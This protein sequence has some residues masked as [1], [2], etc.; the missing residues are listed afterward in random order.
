MNT[1]AHFIYIKPTDE[2]LG[3][4]DYSEN[5]KNKRSPTKTSSAV[6]SVHI[7]CFP[8]NR[9]KK[10]LVSNEPFCEEDI[11]SFA[12]SVKSVCIDLQNNGEDG[13]TVLE[14]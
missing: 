2:S 10:T 1:K 5:S 14:A 11:F 4:Q 9:E 12:A 8:N 13:Y 3:P 6:G 7:R